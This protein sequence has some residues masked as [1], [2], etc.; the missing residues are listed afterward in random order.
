M[1]TFVAMGCNK[2]YASCGIVLFLSYCVS[3]ASERSKRDTIRDVQIRADAVLYIYIYIYIY[4]YLRG[5]TTVAKVKLFST[6]T[7]S[8]VSFYSM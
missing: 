4:I 5:T 8:T 1:R 7:R 2:T 6:W 3:L